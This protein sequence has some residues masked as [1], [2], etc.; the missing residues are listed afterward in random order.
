MRQRNNETEK[1]W[2]REIMRQRNKETGKQWNR[3]KQRDREK[4]FF[5]EQLW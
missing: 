3:K 4:M 2:D 1:Q 5:G